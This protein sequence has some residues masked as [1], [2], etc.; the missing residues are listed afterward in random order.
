M[1]KIGCL[2]DVGILDGN[3]K[4]TEKAKNTFIE[5]VQD[6]IKYGTKNIPAEFTPAFSAGI[7][8]PPNPNPEAIPD[9]KNK[10]IFLHFIKTTLEDTKK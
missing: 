3:G 8:I 9:L 2:D 5:E 7:E 1:A 4:L 10:T 6:I